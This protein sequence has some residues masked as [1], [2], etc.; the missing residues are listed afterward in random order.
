MRS[1]AKLVHSKRILIFDVRSQT[2]AIIV[3]D[4]R[5]EFQLNLMQLRCIPF[6]FGVYLDDI[7]IDFGKVWFPNSF[8]SLNHN[9]KSNK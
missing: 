1:N 8:C 5:H 2:I 7:F 4:I 9:V 6:P 3:V